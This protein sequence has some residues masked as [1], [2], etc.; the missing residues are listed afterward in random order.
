[1]TLPMSE[2]KLT[3][4][5]TGAKGQVGREVVDLAG[6]PDWQDKIELL[7]FDRQSLDICDP[8]AV[9]AV[10]V[11][12][13]PQWVLNCAAYTAV[14]RAETERTQALAINH[15]GSQHLAEQCREHRVRLF[16]LS[17]DY[18]FAGQGE[19][20]YL[21]SDV[22]ASPNVYGQSKLLGERA[23]T[24]QLAEHLILRVSWVFGQ[25]GNNFV[26]TISR[27]LQQRDALS[28]VADQYGGPTPAAAIASTALAMIVQSEQAEKGKYGLY[29]YA[30]APDVS[31]YEF[32]TAIAEVLKELQPTQRLAT[33]QPI[34]TADYG[35]AT[36]R[37]L[38]SRLNCAKIANTFGLERPDWRD[39][40]CTILKLS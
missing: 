9:A 30:G 32:A 8:A 18:V 20:P 4:L 10:L 23:I 17:T 2:Q 36:P 14:D 38:N 27:L 12:A 1:M 40:L 25:Y 35:S 19:I 33:I 5:L 7:S 34:S 16:H 28:I 31:W 11:E 6:S 37:G 24:E 29:H 3:V 39:Y 15:L 13:Q 21:E 22:T 26:K